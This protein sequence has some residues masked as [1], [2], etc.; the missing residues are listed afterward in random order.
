MTDSSDF[1]GAEDPFAGAVNPFADAVNPFEGDNADGGVKGM[2]RHSA[3]SLGG[4]PVKDGNMIRGAVERGGQLLGGLFR[5]G[6]EVAE[7]LDEAVPLGG[8]V[9]DGGALPSYYGPEKYKA[10][11]DENNHKEFLDVAAE[12]FKGTDVGYVPEHTWE[13]VKGEFG[14]NGPLSGS[15]WGEVMMY[16]AEQGV[17]SI[18]DMVGAVLNL[19]GYISARA[20]EIGEER[21]LNKGKQQTDLV[22]VLE[23]AP[24]AVASAVLERIGAKGITEAG[25]E[26]LGKEA[27]QYGFAHAAKKIGSD[28][29]KAGGK[30]AITEFLQEGVIEYLGE[31]LG[32]G[33][34]MSGPEAFDRGLAGA[35][36]GGVYGGAAGT[37]GSA[38]RTSGEIARAGAA[39]EA[40][41]DALEQ[42]VSGINSGLKEEF[43]N[44]NNP[45]ALEDAGTDFVAGKQ[46]VQRSGIGIDEVA[47]LELKAQEEVANNPPLEALQS[48]AAPR[49]YEGT[50]YEYT[51][52]QDANG[53]PVIALL[54]KETGDLQQI[55]NAPVGMTAKQLNDKFES[56]LKERLAKKAAESVPTSAPRTEPFAPPIKPSADDVAIAAAETNTAPSDAQIEADNYKKGRVKYA[57]L[58]IAIENPKGSVRSGSDAGGRRW[59]SKMAHH[60]GDIKGTKG[61]DGDDIDVFIGDNTES[62]KVF[63]VDQVDG[64][65]GKFDEHKVLVGFNSA[66]EAKAGYLANYEE[67]W[68]GLGEISELHEGDFKQWLKEG[69]TTKP[70]RLGTAKADSL[71]GAKADSSKEGSNAATAQA[72]AD[73]EQSNPTAPEQVKPT[74]K[75]APESGVEDTK[76]T[77]SANGKPF[78]SSKSASASLATKIRDGKLEGEKGDYEVVQVGDGFGYV[79]NKPSVFKNKPAAVIVEHQTRKGKTLRGEVR[80]DLTL[81]QAKEIDP[82]TFKKDGG[83]FLREGR[84]ADALDAK[85]TRE[86]ILIGDTSL[87]ESTN[88]SVRP[89]IATNTNSTLDSNDTTGGE[90][91]GLSPSELVEVAEAHNNDISI[92]APLAHVK[93]GVYFGQDESIEW[94]KQDVDKLRTAL[95]AAGISAK[96]AQAAKKPE[97]A[98]PFASSKLP[99]G[100]YTP[101]GR[102]VVL[103]DGKSFQVN[104]KGKVIAITEGAD[105]EVDR[106]LKV[107]Y[108][109][110]KM[111]YKETE[112]DGYL[113]KVINQRSERAEEDSAADAEYGAKNKLVSVDRAAVLREKLKSKLTQLN[114]GID[115]ELMAI[116]TELAVFHIEAGARKFTDLAA[117]MAKDLDTSIDKIKPYLRSWYN[118]ARDMMED[119]DLDVSDMDGP[120]QVKAQLKSLSTE[121]AANT[122]PKRPSGSLSDYLYSRIDELGDN[123]KLKKAVA[124]FNGLAAKD[125]TPEIM[126]SAQEALELALVTKARD[127]VQAGGESQAVYKKLVDLYQNQPNLNVRSSTSMENQ[128]YSTPAPLAYLS[129]LMAGINEQSMVYEPTAGNGMLLIG[130]NPQLVIANELNDLRATQ[131]KAQGYQ[132]TQN[133]ATDFVPGTKVD[134]AIMNPPFGRL[135]GD[136]GR[137]APVKVDGYTVKAIDHLIAA[138]ALESLKD[139]GRAVI[140][141]GAAKKAGDI[142]PAD[143]T[144]FNW[145]YSHYNVVDHFEVDGDLYKRQGAGWPVRLLV[146][147]GRE[148]SNNISPVS[149]SVERVR[150]WDEVYERFT[151]SLDSSKSGSERSGPARIDG[152]GKS[153]S[154]NDT[155]SAAVEI[156]R[157][158][159]TVDTGSAGRG[160]D[161]GRSPTG[162]TGSS[163][164]SAASERAKADSAS[165]SRGG[166]SERVDLPSGDQQGQQQ[167]AR[168]STATEA[169]NPPK[170]TGRSEPRTDSRLSGSDFQSLY[171]TRSSG[172]NES[173]LTP[174]N[175]AGATDRALADLESEVGNLDQFVMNELG[176]DSLTDLHRSFMGLQV[177]TI[178]AGIQNMRN[179]KGIIIADQT[180]VG[181]GRQAAGLLRYALRQGKIPVFVSV[182][183]N[184]FTDMYNDLADIGTEDIR[185]MILNQEA[186]IKQGNKSLFK[187][188][189]R[190]KQI[191]RMLDIIQ[192]GQL[193]EDS[194]MLFLTYSQLNMNNNQRKVIDAIKDR[195]VFVLDESHNAAGEREKITKKG[196]QTTTAGFVYQAIADRPVVYLSATYAKRPDNMPV[197]YRTDLMDAVDSVDELVSAVAAGGAPLQTVM[198]GMLAESGQLFRRERSFDGIEVKTVIDIDNTPEH[199]RIAD[200]VTAGLRAITEA[201]SAF[202]N[203]FVD[204]YAGQIQMEGGDAFGAGNKAESGV[205][206]TN[207][208]SIVHNFISQLLLGLKAKRAAELA[209]ESHKK[210]VKPVLALENTMGSFLNSYVEETGAALGDVV[211]ADYRDVLLR[212]LERTRRISVKEANGDQKAIDIPMSMLDPYTRARYEEAME[213]IERLDIKDLPISPIDYVRDQLEK[214]GISVAEITGRGYRLDYSGDAPV[215]AKRS[216]AEV[217]DRRGTVDGFNGGTLDALVL[218]AAGSTGLSIH[219]SEK[220]TDQKPRHMIVMQAMADINILMQMLGRINRTGQVEKPTFSMMGLNIPAEKR[221]L[222]RTANK[223]KSLNANTSANTDSDTSVDAPDIMNKYGD[224][225]VNDYLK[226]N[227]D[228]SLLVDMSASSID[229]DGSATPGIAIKFTGRLALLPVKKQVEIYEEIEATYNNLIE[230]LN[231]T[232]QN[233]LV[234]S[235]VDMDARIIES[236]V[237]YEGKAPDTLFGGHTVLHKVDAKYQGKPPTPKDVAAALDIALKKETPLEITNAIFTAKSVDDKYENV[238]NDRIEK[239]KTKLS[240]TAAEED[241]DK[242]VSA[243]DGVNHA[244]KSLGD[245]NKVKQASEHLSVIFQVGNRVRLNMGDETVTGV[246]IGLKDSHKAGKGNPYALSKTRV[247]FM[248]NSG[249]RQIELPFSQLQLDGNIY[250]EKLQGVGKTGLED[251]FSSDLAGADRRE[252]RYIATGN[253]IAGSAKLKGR[254]VTFT[255]KRKDTHQGIL[256]P[257]SYGENHEYEELGSSDKFALR[258]SKVL[259]KFLRDNRDMDDVK[260][261]G[262][263]SDNGTIRIKPVPGSRWEII[264]PKSNK[265]AAVRSVKFDDEL[266]DAMGGDFYG[267]G[268]AMTA[269][270]SDSQLSAV[271]PILNDL[272]LLKGLPSMRDDWIAAG[273]SG[274]P[275]AEKAF[276]QDGVDEKPNKEADSATASLFS[277]G[278][279]VSGQGI[280]AAA[281]Q[282]VVKRITKGW[283][284]APSIQVLSRVDELPKAILAEVKRRQPRN[285][286]GLRT[287]AGEIYLIAEN[288]RGPAHAERV[289]AHEVIGH[290]AME[291]SLGKDFDALLANVQ[292]L[293][294]KGDKVILKYAAKVNG[295]GNPQIESAEIIA[296]MAE[297]TVKHPVMTKLLTWLR[298]LLKSLGFDAAIG[299]NAEIMKLLQAAMQYVKGRDTKADNSEEFDDYSELAFSADKDGLKAERK[300]REVKFTLEDD[301][302]DWLGVDPAAVWADVVRLQAKHP[303]MF[304]TDLDVMDHLK[305]VLVGASIALPASKA[306][307][308]LLVATSPD[309]ILHRSSVVEF[310][311]KGGKYRVRNAQFMPEVQLRSKLDKAKKEGESIKTRG[312]KGRDSLV[313]SEKTQSEISTRSSMLPSD[314][315]QSASLKAD[316]TTSDKTIE[317]SEQKTTNTKPPKKDDGVLFSSDTPE[318]SGYGAV[319]DLTQAVRDSLTNVWK[320]NWTADLRPAWLATLTRR[321]LADIAGKA[322][323]QIKQYVRLAQ[324]MDARRNELLAANAKIAEHWTKFNIKNREEAKRLAQ[325]MHDATLA[326]VDPS[327]PY[328]A[329]ITQADVDE[330]TQKNKILMKDR[331][332]DGAGGRGKGVRSDKQL[333]EEIHEAEM[334]LAQERNRAKAKKRLAGQ[335]RALSPE[336]QAIFREVRDAYKSQQEQTLA[337]LEARIGRSVTDG[338]QAKALLDSLREQF[339][340]VTVEDPYFP[341]ARFGKYW[342]DAQ[343]GDERIFEMFESTREQEAHMERMRS[344][345]YKVRHG[346]SLDSLKELDGVSA[347][348]VNDIEGLL[349]EKLGAFTE[350]D[351]IKDEIYQMY[352][353]S[354]PDLSVRKNFIHRKKVEG[355]AKD[356]LRAFADNTFHGAYQL[357][358]LEYS[359]LLGGQLDEMK[360]GLEANPDS[361]KEQIEIHKKAQNLM[362]LDE[363]SLRSMHGD[364]VRAL[365][366]DA[367]DATADKALKAVKLA[368]KYKEN[369]SKQHSEYAK[370]V[371]SLGAYNQIGGDRVKAAHLYN[372]MLKRHDWAMNPKGS[373]WANKVSSFGFTWYLGVS[374]AAALVNVTQTAL[375]AYPILAAKFGW[376]QAA[377]A[378]MNSSNDYFA[379]GFG[380]EKALKGDRLRAYRE[381][382]RTGVIDKTLAHDLAGLAQ[383]G[384]AYNPV[385][386]MIMEKVA[387]LFHNA[388]RYNREVTYMAAYDL[389]RNKGKNHVQ[390]VEYAHDL[391]WESHFD[392]SSGNKARFMQNDFAKV[393]LMFRQFSLNMTYLLV[394]N[395]HNSLKGE[396]P[397][398]KTQARKQLAGVLGMHFLFAGAMGMPLFSVLGSVMEAVFDDEDEPWKFDAEFRNFLADMFGKDAGRILSHGIANETGFNIASRVSLDGLWIREPLKEL[399]GRDKVAYW[400]EQLL[401]PVGGI[402]FSAGTA[403]DLWNEGHELRAV[404]SAVPKFVKDGLRAVRYGTEGAKT[405]RG[406]ALVESFSPQVLI[407]QAMGL[408][409]AELMERYEANG[410]IKGIERRIKDRRQN[411]INRFALAYRLS[412]TS[413]L[414]AVKKKIVRFNAANPRARI[415]YNTLMKSYRTR[416]RYSHDQIKGITVD[417]K[418]RYLTENG[419]FAE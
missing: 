119:S 73:Y 10:W 238:L 180:G 90:L 83:Y 63:I 96:D 18:P 130:A 410:A 216:T 46:G 15:A 414:A 167:S 99:D 346:A 181:K 365:E 200:T 259:V 175:M 324:E 190:T 164:R 76:P 321:H 82:Y 299:A 210:G 334:K 366:K 67:N 413:D 39:Q 103:R 229:A 8:F 126:K 363:R 144:F 386:S 34:E 407:A 372:E 125:V 141:I 406:D 129:S 385:H 249:I 100:V 325:M 202:H 140:I 66:A 293:K 80:T 361:L 318:G 403:V 380:V 69:D 146:V 286:Q 351:A 268:S 61:A 234:P 382:V 337:A 315:S 148:Q 92:G 113:D 77:I 152:A 127:I 19:P 305:K 311:F 246:V 70:F 241:G 341:L 282:R 320:K 217:K 223:M 284:N 394:R 276:A 281:A 65:S 166:K 143:R 107:L 409:P 357:A 329:I 317:E 285:L 191:G 41:I 288:I 169:A 58:D 381:A 218:N 362:G 170:S 118:G 263:G 38:M 9:N 262:I 264:I 297:D 352:L 121:V 91:S 348:F 215:L 302:F 89:D 86:Q 250:L 306:E 135:K 111:V 203:I 185:P 209:I 344:A 253:L 309:A 390:A 95:E 319:K 397:E 228:V 35:V 154:E 354:L 173:V 266:R 256:L 151:E 114:S 271:V 11:A 165:A 258:D 16:A 270:F 327:K 300:G 74:A 157:K 384:A 255:D 338:A 377:E 193:P 147:N 27:L 81:E 184:L 50:R 59:E 336:A 290:W 98:D 178:A 359:D 358:R 383:E 33:A 197:Y 345:G 31:K 182:K 236:K 156:S 142:G 314:S 45:F 136:D 2:L 158:T 227:H 161:T 104:S 172:S 102:V 265:D 78:K 6:N 356:A 251:I 331:A 187:N 242:A 145:L 261:H 350:V 105:P 395:A 355:F 269:T 20:G 44:A 22:D 54:D 220:F 376:G 419:R 51:E 239:A 257:L 171:N 313:P 159:R 94:F 322:L 375:V 79:T 194:N 416:L 248:V 360:D 310:E 295:E 116:G 332:R 408:S 398:V 304:E 42:S 189:T 149:G 340:S 391:T 374:P 307:Y 115:P 323:P 85:N 134:A 343:K 274:R 188:P 233:D 28:G 7:A 326:G 205:D 137:A 211:D 117:V 186:V 283:N 132:V 120:D 4:E 353:K 21:A 57:G 260:K 240:N 68:Q 371:R 109:K 206:H 237:A 252:I 14:S 342:V 231:K 207:F 177:D 1:S 312:F 415:T 221:P 198:S 155:P 131:L 367:K 112:G 226:E 110:P 418:L 37:A 23:A 174:V 388:E 254:I 179:G 417:K 278:K 128:A 56:Q 36:A 303:D 122:K 400:M 108:R 196:K 47:E 163:K 333:R 123:R 17:K 72:Y 30:E 316:N 244:E 26:A 347:A 411:L 277:D 48:K 43:K 75:Q 160:L 364:H 402:A 199:T 243:Q 308:T 245:Y 225:V 393:A 219:A 405:L 301:F 3:A 208:T 389:A 235:V 335:W 62:E 201:D 84:I 55:D 272:A 162:G 291:Q 195:A 330:I 399:E 106:D 183:D 387:F 222:A 101:N 32:T 370:M 349:E 392:Y 24:A 168:S 369:E 150:T 368:F 29:L 230:Y 289:L 412:D 214:A 25:K 373:A 52:S 97:D 275:D 339:E 298:K 396:T 328:K 232:N 5:A 224:R 71:D 139:D 213:V 133:D 273:G 280:S 87:N 212:A 49:A 124:E 12:G 292:A 247:S 379:G 60:Y 64:K 176:Y 40:E 88:E 138:K 204:Q 13:K 153:D 192:T 378:L 294:D 279:P 93:E 287:P 404:E 53:N 296:K 401:G 267:S